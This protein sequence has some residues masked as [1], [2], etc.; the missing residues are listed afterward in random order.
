VR[1]LEETRRK[2]RYSA[3][4]LK[5][6]ALAF[7]RAWMVAVKALRAVHPDLAQQLPIFE[8]RTQEKEPEEDA[9]AGTGEEPV[10]ESSAQAEVP[11]SEQETRAAAPQLEAPGEPVATAPRSEGGVQPTPA[12]PSTGMPRLNRKQRRALHRHGK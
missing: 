11:Q 12:P 7:D 6:K 10:L 2:R 9:S 3:K 1:L 8:A 5:D 4:V